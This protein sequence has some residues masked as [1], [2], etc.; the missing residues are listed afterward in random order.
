[1]VAELQ[2]QYAFDHVEP[3]LHDW[4]I[5]FEEAR[6][7]QENIPEDEM[8]AEWATYKE[9]ISHSTDSA[10]SIRWR[11]D[12]MLRSL[13]EAHPTIPLKDNQRLFT[14]AQRLA[15]FRRDKGHC[16]VKLK[17]EGIKLTWDDW[18]CDHRIAWTSGGSTTVKNGQVACTACNLAKGA[19]GE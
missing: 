15:I 14:Q 9:K 12:F 1:V 3:L 8:D 16:Q 4:F 17:C 11:M 2:R 7:T 18:H 13:L 6:R 19:T 5:S 10:D